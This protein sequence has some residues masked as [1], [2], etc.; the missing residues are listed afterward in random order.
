MDECVLM[1]SIL[2]HLHVALI[3]LVCLLKPFFTIGCI[4]S[5]MLQDTDLV[6]ILAVRH[7]TSQTQQQ[8]KHN[9]C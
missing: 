4:D 8:V 5:D 6:S 7:V 1:I 2:E 9:T 3:L